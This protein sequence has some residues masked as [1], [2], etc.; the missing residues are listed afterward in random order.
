[1]EKPEA[2]ADDYTDVPDD[3]FEDLTAGTTLGYQHKRKGKGK[4]SLKTNF[5]GWGLGITNL[6]AEIDLT[7]HLSLAIPVYY[8]GGYDYFSPYMKF[9]C[10]ILQ[11]ELRYYPWVRDDINTGFF[12]GAHAGAGF[13]NYAL[14]GDYRIQ[15]ARGQRPAYGGGLSLG[16]K[17]DFRKNPSWGMEFVVGGGVYDA[18]YDLFYNEINGPY[19]KR[20]IHKL[21]YGVDNAA[22]SLCY[23]FGMKTKG[24][25]RK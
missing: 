12:I 9:R 23:R 10:L 15:D 4:F 1:M 20:G 22:I 2:E 11:P 7:R 24:G 13:Y 3:I 8:S 5:L 18:E 14:N 17:V 21:W 16:Y 6:A 19:Y 25:T